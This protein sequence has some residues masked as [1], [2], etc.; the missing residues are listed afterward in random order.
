MVKHGPVILL[1]HNTTGPVGD[2]MTTTTARYSLTRT[3]G[4]SSSMVRRR[5]IGDWR[6]AIPPPLPYHPGVCAKHDDDDGDD[7]GVARALL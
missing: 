1:S 5:R 2:F 7:G 3:H 4:S 6:F